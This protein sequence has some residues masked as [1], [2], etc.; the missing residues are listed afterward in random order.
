MT[1]TLLIAPVGPED[2][3]QV[4]S[5]SGDSRRFDD[6]QDVVPAIDQDAT[7][8]LVLPG[9][10]AIT[11][12][13]TLP[14]RSSRDVVRAA[15]LAL[16]DQRALSDDELFVA[17][18]SI[19]DGQ[20]TV[21]G[22]PR[23]LLVAAL[24]DVQAAGLEPDLV[25]V[26]H[27]ALAIGEDET[28][29]WDRG[30]LLA[31]AVAD[32]GFTVEH[33][34]AESL[35]PGTDGQ[36]IVQTPELFERLV[37]EPPNFRRGPFAKHRQLPDLSAF[38]LAASLMLVASIVYLVSVAIE[39]VRY[40]RQATLMRDAVEAEFRA[41]FPGTP[42]VDLERQVRSRT[43]GVS[44]NGD[45]LPLTAALAEVMAEREDTSLTSLRFGA[46]G[47]LAAEIQF[48]EFDGLETLRD[49]L[50]DRGVA[51]REA[52]DARRE[53]NAYVTQLYLRAG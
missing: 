30:D 44:A 37:D 51:A 34:F 2:P 22:L 25:T 52:G 53:N 1:R 9:D 24:D 36:R 17:F 49:A 19:R 15:G 18:G 12:T 42:I 5:E 35:L 4:L 50:R 47:E 38:K 31:I 33:A 7:L 32:G 23:A 13:M 3:W 26:D 39:G 10:Q 29:G 45:F 8:W 43:N 20:R 16:D 21:V 28:I 14:M 6:L 41:A 48:Q 11:R 46:E 27:A 40:T